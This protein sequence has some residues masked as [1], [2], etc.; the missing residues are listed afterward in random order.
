M[1]SYDFRTAADLTDPAWDRLINGIADTA[2]AMKN[3]VERFGGIT[4]ALREGHG[5]TL[6][7]QLNELA[8]TVRVLQRRL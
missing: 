2:M 6:E 1:Y 4:V 5:S 3:Q 7:G 8:S